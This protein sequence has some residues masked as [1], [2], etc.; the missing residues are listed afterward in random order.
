M[1]KNNVSSTT[2]IGILFSGG[3]DSTFTVYYYTIQGW[4][5]KCLITLKSKNKASYMFHTPNIDITK[6]QAQAMELPLIEQTTKGEKETELQ[7]LKKAFEKAKKQYKIE[8]IAVGAVAS[9]YQAERVNRICEE[10][11]LK[12]FAPLWHKN[13][14]LLL[15]DMIDNGFCIIIQ[16]IAAYGL[17]KQWLGRQIT[18]DALNELMTLHTK[19]GLH[20]AG[21]G[22]EYES[23]VLDAPIFKKKLVIKKAT[24]IIEDEN[25]GILL[26][27]KIALK[28]KQTLFKQHK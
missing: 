10:L 27:E 3:K 23:L 4:D 19:F 14:E 28:K 5:V 18:K 22:G 8:G 11:Q 1:N 16:S 2:K 7:D 13:Q 20:P 24:P 17:T 12:C 21:E 25:T 26:I 6:L 15:K 9:D